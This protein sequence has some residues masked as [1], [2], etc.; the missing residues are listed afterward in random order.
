[1][2]LRMR[3]PEPCADVHS[4][5][6]FTGGAVG[7]LKASACDGLKIGQ[8][9]YGQQQQHR[10]VNTTSCPGCLELTT[11]GQETRWAYIP[12][13]ALNRRMA[14]IYLLIGDW[15]LYGPIR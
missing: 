15:T 9:S 4:H 1:M 12:Q 13:H 2:L 3:A 6:P 11:V 10:P 14:G 7:L 8:P 5:A